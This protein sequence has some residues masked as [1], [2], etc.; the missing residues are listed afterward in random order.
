MLGNSGHS[1]ALVVT[2]LDVAI[3]VALNHGS[4]FKRWI[5]ARAAL[6]CGSF[7]LIYRTIDSNKCLGELAYVMRGRINNC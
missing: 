1:S 3:L 5:P 4:F 7:S 6:N 2:I